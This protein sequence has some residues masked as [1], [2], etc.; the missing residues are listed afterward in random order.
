MPF[1]KKWHFLTHNLLADTE[2][3]AKNC[4]TPT[5]HYSEYLN[6]DINGNLQKICKL[7]K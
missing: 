6:I 2:L 4:I 5:A 7:Y 1:S 3:Y